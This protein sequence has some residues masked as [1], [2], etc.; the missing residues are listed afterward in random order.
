MSSSGQVQAAPV[1]SLLSVQGITSGEQLQSQKN[2]WFESSKS[3]SRL[4]F[5]PVVQNRSLV[6]VAGGAS[7]AAGGQVVVGRQKLDP[8]AGWKVLKGHGLQEEIACDVS[9]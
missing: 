8:T 9:F 5:S 4:F 3:L 1:G 7:I 6:G 2:H